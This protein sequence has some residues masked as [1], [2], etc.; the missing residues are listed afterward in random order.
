MD[1][2]ATNNFRPSGELVH[3]SEA[4]QSAIARQA[5]ELR[6][7]FADACPLVLVLMQ[8]AV[9]YA[10]WLT[11]A[12]AIP[13]ELDYVDVG[14]YGDGHAGG[15]LGWRRPPSK[16]VAG[17]SVLV[18]D[19]IFDEGETLAAVCAA[20]NEAGASA[21]HTAVLA[22]KRHDRARAAAPDSAALE[23]PD[24]FIVGCGLDYAGR[25]RNL[26]ALYALDESAFNASA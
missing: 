22:R 23:V 4:V 1:R 17:R 8:G 5:A 10:V 21:V 16:R 25:W 11:L 14:R 3:S 26:P 6:L 13:L 18:V 24:R 19:D 20:C 12:L 9:Y 2:A 15:A 7:R